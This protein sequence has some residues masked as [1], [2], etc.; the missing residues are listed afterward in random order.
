MS[1]GY[2]WMKLTQPCCGSKLCILMVSGERYCLVCGNET[3]GLPDA[4]SYAT[5]W[6]DQNGGAV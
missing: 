5:G 2:R 4:T 6:L 1:M 3:D